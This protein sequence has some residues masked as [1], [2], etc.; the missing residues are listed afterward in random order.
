MFIINVVDLLSL[1]IVIISLLLF[2]LFLLIIRI[3]EWLEDRKSKKNIEIQKNRKAA[4]NIIEV[5]EN[6][7][8]K[9][10]IKIPNED[11]ENNTD[12]SC[13]YG[14][15]YYELEDT[16]TSILNHKSN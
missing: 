9:K 10:N 5:F 4:I 6:L 16:I 14:S 7:L 11:R 1:V 8:E 12:E 3:Q 15:D 13:I 2:G